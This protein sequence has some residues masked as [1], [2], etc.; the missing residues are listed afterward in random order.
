MTRSADPRPLSRHRFLETGDPGEARARV[1]ELFAPH[2]LDLPDGAARFHT[3]YHHVRLRALSLYY[4][5]YSSEVVIR[6]GAMER[7]YLL[8]LPAAGFCAVD[9]A[10]CR[11]EVPALKEIAPGH[12]SACHLNDQA[13]PQS[14]AA[15][16]ETSP[17]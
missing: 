11:V 10:G 16:H 6:S 7:D 4:F 9:Y 2:Q 14:E 13:A 17:T 8:L 1:S 5:E 15:A 3:V 12:R